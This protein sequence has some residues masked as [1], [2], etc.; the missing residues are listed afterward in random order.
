MGPSARGAKGPVRFRMG[1]AGAG[2][3][4]KRAI[5]GRGPA[6]CR[7]RQNRYRL[8]V[9]IDYTVVDFFDEVEG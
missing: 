4:F 8:R 9:F 1:R 5:C 2:R 7:Q 6:R 3:P